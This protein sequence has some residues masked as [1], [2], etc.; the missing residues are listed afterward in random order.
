MMATKA[1]K[2]TRE[3]WYDTFAEWGADDQ[4][5]AIELLT[6]MNRQTYAFEKRLGKKIGLVE[7]AGNNK[8]VVTTPVWPCGFCA[9][10]ET[11][12]HLD[13][14]PNKAAPVQATLL[15]AEPG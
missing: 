9:A 8:P 1:K 7:V 3:T 14:C 15:E 11:E 10:K 5:R 4:A 12:G 2:G 6:A 13:K